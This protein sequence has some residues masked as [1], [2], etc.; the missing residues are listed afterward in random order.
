MIKD[1]DAS[2]DKHSVASQVPIGRAAIAEEIA[3]TAIFLASEAASYVTGAELIVD[4]G[5]C[6]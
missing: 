4:G 1:A 5:W 6:A 3:S 2:R